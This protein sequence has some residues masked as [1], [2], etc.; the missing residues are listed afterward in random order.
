MLIRMN[1]VRNRVYKSR[2][3]IKTHLIGIELVTFGASPNVGAIET[4]RAGNTFSRLQKIFLTEISKP[5]KLQSK[6]ALIAATMVKEVHP[7]KRK[8]ILY[9]F[10]FLPNYNKFIAM[11]TFYYS[12]HASRRSRAVE[13]AQKI[14][15]RGSSREETERCWSLIV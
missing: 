10:S 2:T 15:I 13:E 4:V 14:S 12:F 9:D 7:K 3:V 8:G 6:S 11:L 1:A 5:R